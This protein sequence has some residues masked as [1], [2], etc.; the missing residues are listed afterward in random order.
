M[1]LTLTDPNL[2]LVSALTGFD[3]VFLSYY[4]KARKKKKLDLELFLIGIIHLV[5]TQNFPKNYYFSPHDTYTYVRV[6]GHKKC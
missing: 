6:S 2:I 1:R 5:Q 3:N 4:K